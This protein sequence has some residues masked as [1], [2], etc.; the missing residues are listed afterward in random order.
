MIC[1]MNDIAKDSVMADIKNR[2]VIFK[3]AQMKFNVLLPALIF[4]ALV[5]STAK[6]QSSNTGQRMTPT[7][8]DAVASIG[9]GPGTSGV[10]GVQT[11]ILKGE[12]NKFN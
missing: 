11:R 1:S 3:E 8:I 4:A 5:V 2:S 9:A 7:E 10:N 6:G 12:P